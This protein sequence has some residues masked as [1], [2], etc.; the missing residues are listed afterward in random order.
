M[1]DVLVADDESAARESIALILD[2]EDD[3]CVIGTASGG[4]QALDMSAK[5]H[6]DVVVMDLR[7]P[8]MDGIA[9]TQ[10]LCNRARPHP[11][12]LA[13]TTFATDE[14]ALGA[15][16]AGAAGFCAKADPP[17]MLADAVRTV[18]A[19]DAVVSPRVLKALLGRLIAPASAPKLPA[20]M[21]PREIDVLLLVAQGEPNGTIS[22]ALSIS[23]ATVRSHVAHLRTKLGAR[24]RA[25]LVVR[26]WEAGLG[27]GPTNRSLKR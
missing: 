26:A 24:T 23:D 4:Q 10:A 17:A 19:G 7:M 8:G 21:T 1:I 12:V 27:S 16:R 15:I 9:A 18:A 25:E 20:E 5:L 11:A 22:K 2:A 13:L 3:L 14:M 6:P